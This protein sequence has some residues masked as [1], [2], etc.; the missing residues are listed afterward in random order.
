[1]ACIM[2]SDEMEKPHPLPRIYA[3]V[4]TLKP[5]RRPS[6]YL[7]TAVSLGLAVF[8]WSAAVLAILVVW[9]EVVR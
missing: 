5:R 9:V 2:E 1:V 3:E 4:W 6:N 7:R 8:V